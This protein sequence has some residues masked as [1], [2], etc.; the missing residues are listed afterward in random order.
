M[1]ISNILNESITIGELERI[2]RKVYIDEIKKQMK[3]MRMNNDKIHHMFFVAVK[4]K[5]LSDK[6]K[7]DIVKSLN[8]TIKNKPDILERMDSKK[9]EKEIR[10][11]IAYKVTQYLVAAAK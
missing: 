11:Q 8:I 10:N 1:K 2:V 5:T 4:G 7:N 3:K 9:A 6:I